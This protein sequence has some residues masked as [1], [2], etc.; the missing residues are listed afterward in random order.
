MVFLHGPSLESSPP[1]PMVTS[2]RPGITRACCRRPFLTGGS[3]LL[4]SWFAALTSIVLAPLFW[5]PDTCLCSRIGRGRSASRYA[6][7]HFL[8]ELALICF[9]FVARVYRRLATL[10][11]GLFAA[12]GITLSL[13]SKARDLMPWQRHSPL[14]LDFWWLPLPAIG[15]GCAARCFWVVL[16]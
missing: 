7:P 8:G 14:P 2:W 11:R 13:P 15:M 9:R 3:C 12:G 5:H 1:L 6:V 10:F 4:R 16:Y